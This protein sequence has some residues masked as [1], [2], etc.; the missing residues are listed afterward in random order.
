[1]SCLI[2]PLVKEKTRP[3]DLKLHSDVRAVE[4]ADFDQQL[5]EKMNLIEQYKM[6]IERQQKLAEEEEVRRL[7]KELVPK[8]QPMPY[9]DRPFIPRSYGGVVVD[10]GKVL[11]RRAITNEARLKFSELGWPASAASQPFAIAPVLYAIL[12]ISMPQ[13][14][15]CCFSDGFI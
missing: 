4:R 14:W 2:K 12:S 1:M 11:T 3:I 5:A 7:R 9:F 15:I 10:R 6:E 13:A 8:A